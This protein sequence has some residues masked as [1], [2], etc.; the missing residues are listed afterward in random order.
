MAT[1]SAGDKNQGIPKIE[2]TTGV[3]ELVAHL[4]DPEGDPIETLAKIQKRLAAWT[5]VRKG[6][7]GTA[8][9]R[10]KRVSPPSLKTDCG[11]LPID[12]HQPFD[13][14]QIPINWGAEGIYYLRVYWGPKRIAQL[15][16][17]DFPEWR[18]QRGLAEAPAQTIL[19]P[20]P[21]GIPIQV[22]GNQQ[23]LLLQ[24][25]TAI[26]QQQKESNEAVA[27]ALQANTETMRA[28]LEKSQNAQP[29]STSISDQLDQMSSAADKLKKFQKVLGGFGGGGAPEDDNPWVGLVREIVDE[30]GEDTITGAFQ[31]IHSWR[32][33]KEKDKESPEQVEG[34]VIELPKTSDGNGE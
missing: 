24:L 15:G 6:S 29:E 23:N 14:G 19:P 33:S 1:G 30:Y 20:Q 32:D 10:V 17:M 4:D 12:L 22:S 21:Q 18:Q 31:V 9:L 11:D 5:L 28:I 16:V 25:V 7:D 2:A 34:T 26:T 8:I 13:F 27:Q 3:V